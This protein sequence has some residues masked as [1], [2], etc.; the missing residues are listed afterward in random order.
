[1]ELLPIVSLPPV[2][3]LVDRACPHDRAHLHEGAVVSLQLCGFRSLIT[4]LPSMT[5]CALASVA[6]CPVGLHCAVENPLNRSFNAD[7]GSNSSKPQD[8]TAGRNRVLSSMARGLARTQ[9]GSCHGCVGQPWKNQISK[10]QSS[11]QGG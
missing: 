7:L 3:E 6:P 4:G 9:K 5:P 8:N 10:P 1:M 11:R 2:L